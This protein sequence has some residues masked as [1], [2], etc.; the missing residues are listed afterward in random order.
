MKKF[1]KKLPEPLITVIFEKFVFIYVAGF[2]D[3]KNHTMLI[4]AFAKLNDPNTNLLL[5]GKGRTMDEAIETAEKLGVSDRVFFE[6]HTNNP[7]KYLARSDCFVSSSDFE[8]FPNVQLEALACKLPIISTDCESGPREL[9]AYR[10][11]YDEM[12]KDDFEIC[13]HGILTPV[14]N[15]DL[16]AAA[17]KRM[18]EDENLRENFKEKALKRAMDFS[19]ENVINYFCEIIEN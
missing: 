15:A 6:G 19:V 16:L 11:N 18:V 1:E 9:L 13:E 8:G 3:G 7:Y 2:R 17:M 12:L 10:E 14:G 5:L 4:E